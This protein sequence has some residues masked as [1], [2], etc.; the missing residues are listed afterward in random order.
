MQAGGNWSRNLASYAALSHGRAQAHAALVA[1][2]RVSAPMMEA[3]SGADWYRADAISWGPPPAG[4]S[5][6]ASQPSLPQAWGSAPRLLWPPPPDAPQQHPLAQSSFV[7]Y[8]ANLGALSDDMCRRMLGVCGP[9]LD[10]QRPKDTANNNPKGFAVC[11]MRGEEAAMRAVRLIS[12]LCVDGRGISLK[13]SE[14]HELIVRGYLL[15]GS[16]VPTAERDIEDQ[17]TKRLIIAMVEE[18]ARSREKEHCSS[19]VW[20]PRLTLPGQ[21]PQPLAA[22]PDKVCAKSSAVEN[23]ASGDSSPAAAIK[24]IFDAFDSDGDGVLC[25]QEYSRFCEVTENGKGCGTLRWIKHCTSLGV[26]VNAWDSRCTN[27]LDLVHFARLYTDAKYPRHHGKHDADMAAARR[28]E[29][30][31]KSVSIATSFAPN[32]TRKANNSLGQPVADP[33]E[34]VPNP[35]EIGIDVSDAVEAAQQDA[36][37]VRAAESGDEK[38]AAM[39][40]DSASNGMSGGLD[41]PKQQPQ[42]SS[43]PVCIFFSTPRGCY[44]GDNCRFRHENAEALEPIAAFVSDAAGRA[45]S[46]SPRGGSSV[47]QANALVHTKVPPIDEVTAREQ[48]SPVQ[49]Q[50]GGAV[51]THAVALSVE[52]PAGINLGDSAQLAAVQQGLVDRMCGPRGVHVAFF[53]KDGDPMGT[54]LELARCI[55]QRCTATGG[56]SVELLRVDLTSQ[57]ARGLER[58]RALLANLIGTVQLQLQRDSE[59]M[60]LVSAQVVD[61]AKALPAGDIDASASDERGA[62]NAHRAEC[63]ASVNSNIPDAQNCSADGTQAIGRGQKRARA[64]SAAHIQTWAR[65]ERLVKLGAELVAAATALAKSVEYAA[66][67]PQQGG[68]DQR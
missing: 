44:Y 12:G 37:D 1:P 41:G 6:F 46:A 19:G 28:R 20:L 54:K 55:H 7:L 58:G 66:E 8:A 65:R 36:A 4:H 61:A 49:E 39:K 16:A 59:H 30:L 60:R 14:A 52:F 64:D 34:N 21:D 17:R 22:G 31:D 45:R 27:G 26:D 56:N 29:K 3:R 11:T 2:P 68:W 40:E 13:L 24:E 42:N 48:A 32:Q 51:F 57:S 67:A 38:C 35:T 62:C 25:Y 5:G 10:W 63:G 50:A 33:P 18:Y 53:N 23:S 15:R 9:V 47:S 43:V